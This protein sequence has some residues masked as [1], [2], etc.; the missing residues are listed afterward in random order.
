MWRSYWCGDR[1][2]VEIAFGMAVS[3]W[4]WVPGRWLCRFAD[5]WVGAMLRWFSR[6][7]M[8]VLVLCFGG[9]DE[10]RCGAGQVVSGFVSVG[11]AGCRSG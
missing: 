4:Q 10:L 3:F 11:C 5:D 7:G 6:I 9:V 2:G 1:V 8:A